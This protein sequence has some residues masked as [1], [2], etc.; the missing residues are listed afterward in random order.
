MKVKI[1]HHRGSDNESVGEGGGT[2][3]SVPRKLSAGNDRCEKFI[4][5][6]DRQA[7]I[8]FAG[9]SYIEENEHLPSS[10]CK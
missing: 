5:E 9:A 7:A 2:P 10:F 4:C 3:S 6:C 1:S 8:C